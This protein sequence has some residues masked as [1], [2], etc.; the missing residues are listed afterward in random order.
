[1]AIGVGLLGVGTVGAGVAAIFTS[2]EGRNPL[3]SELELRRVTVRNPRRPRPVQL[4]ADRLVTDPRMV[5]DDP[6]VEI[7]VEVMGGGWSRPVPSSCGPS[8]PR[9]RW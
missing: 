6:E 5:V 7:V 3:V 9:S 4:A 1:M 2:P 8:P